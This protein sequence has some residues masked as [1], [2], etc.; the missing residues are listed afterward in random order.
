MNIVSVASALRGD[1]AVGQHIT[2]RGWIR[3]K[4]DSKAGISFLAIHDGS[5]FDAIQAV[6][7]NDLDNY[8][9]EVLQLGAGCSVVV[10]GLLVASQGKGQQYEIQASAVEVVGWVEDAVG[11]IAPFTLPETWTHGCIMVLNAVE[12]LYISH[13]LEHWAYGCIMALIALETWYFSDHVGTWTHRLIMV[14]MQ[15]EHGTAL[16]SNFMCA[17]WY[18]KL[19]TTRTTIQNGILY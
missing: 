2:V 4:R 17:L 9:S 12:T 16:F 6:I 3:S 19:R 10:S 13:H 5:C 15:V 11:N 1:T 14:L 18:I 8:E 7:P